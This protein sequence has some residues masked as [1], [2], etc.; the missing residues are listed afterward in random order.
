[1]KNLDEKRIWNKFSTG[2]Q[3]RFFTLNKLKTH[4]TDR[5]KN[6]FKSF[7]CIRFCSSHYDRV[8]VNARQIGVK[9]LIIIQDNTYALHMY[10]CIALS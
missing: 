6:N 2:K 7:Y 3:F 4:I 5:I 10:V 1:M 9:K 8:D